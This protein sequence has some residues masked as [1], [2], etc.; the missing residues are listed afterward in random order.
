MPT[1]RDFLLA[2]QLQ[3]A[4]RYSVSKAEDR[5]REPNKRRPG[6]TGRRRHGMVLLS[7]HRKV[8]A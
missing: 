1:N 6:V 7:T 5:S 3:P 2:S 4:R 8:F